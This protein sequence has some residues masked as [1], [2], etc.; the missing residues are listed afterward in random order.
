LV[1]WADAQE[2][3]RLLF[4][5]LG[6]L[7]SQPTP[8]YPFV[9][10]A[11]TG[12]WELPDAGDEVPRAHGSAP[13]KWL[14]AHNPRG[15]L[16]AE[17][18][19]HLASDAAARAAVVHA[20]LKRFFHDDSAAE[21]LAMTGLDDIGR[22][23]VDARSVRDP[24]WVWDELVL[25]CDLVAGNRW[26][27][28]PSEHP[29]VVELSGLL[30]SLPIHSAAA[31]GAKFRS[32][33]SVRRKMADL[34]TRHPDSA[35]KPTN[36]GKLDLE[37]LNAF[38]ERPEE[39]HAIATLLRS[40]ADTGEFDDLPD[41]D[42]S[43]ID[44]YGA[45]EGRLLKRRH[46]RREREPRLRKRKIDKV[47]KD[48]GRLECEVC[49][50]DFQRTYGA[51]GAG[52]SECHHIVPLHASGDTITLLEDLAVL[53]ANCHRMIHR[54]T[55]WLTPAEHE[56]VGAMA[57]DLEVQGEFWLPGEE[58]RKV[59][60]ILTF[61]GQGSGRL[62]LIGSLATSEIFN[63]RSKDYRRIL[64]EDGKHMYTLDD[65]LRTKSTL[66]FPGGKKRQG[67][68]VG[69]II[70]RT[71]AFEKGEAVNVDGLATRMSYLVDWVQLDGIRETE[72]FDEGEPPRKD[73][74]IVGEWQPSLTC[75]VDGGTLK[76]GHE[77]KRTHRG[78]YGLTVEQETTQSSTSAPNSY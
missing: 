53:C 14:R 48:R 41:A 75:T 15:G 20:L 63:N 24:A 44:D 21:A 4:I 27:E 76:L 22:G 30:R 16:P 8:E 47:L 72:S 71:Y 45:R 60:G 77:L 13:V 49:E 9:A 42:D 65:C 29:L 52:Y 67:F 3:L 78:V 62:A 73:W 74:E 64:G 66:M 32:P 2:Q 55:T 10:L 6:R 34:A 5:A 58:E 38:L 39:M 57:E 68:R 18:Y 11:G 23:S 54:G 51:R 1:R 12:W 17:M 36:G 56:E 28:L 7:G 59:A 43:M 19:S 25:A 70:R 33:D 69:R 31:R 26:H 37:V 50:F 40:G 61:S 46:L 35:R